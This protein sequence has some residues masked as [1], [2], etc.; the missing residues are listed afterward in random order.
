MR[1][2][3]SNFDPEISDSAINK[4]WESLQTKLSVKDASILKSS[5]VSLKTIAIG[6]VILSG[7]VLSAYFFAKS[8]NNSTNITAQKTSVSNENKNRLKLKTYTINNTN[9]DEPDLIK[10]ETPIEEL[11]TQ[12]EK[13]EA[14]TLSLNSKSGIAST[15]AEKGVTQKTGKEEV[16]KETTTTF[17]KIDKIAPTTPATSITKKNESG[18]EKVNET[19]S[20]E[21]AKKVLPVESK[22]STYE[23]SLTNNNGAL[24][25]NKSTTNIVNTV[26][27]VDSNLTESILPNIA[28]NASSTSS[29]EVLNS[30]VTKNDKENT[31]ENSNTGTTNPTRYA[32]DTIT[33]TEADVN[34]TNANQKPLDAIVYPGKLF[35]ELFGGY[36]LNQNKIDSDLI[37]TKSNTSGY[38]F[39]VAIAYRII[40]RIAI[41]GVFVFSKNKLEVENNKTENITTNIIQSIGDSLIQVDSLSVIKRSTL[42]SKFA[43]SNLFNYRTTFLN[44]Y[45]YG[46]GL[47]YSLLETNK[48][49]VDVSLSYN[50]K[51]TKWGLEKT[52]RYSE[53]ISSFEQSIVQNTL[54]FTPATYNPLPG[55]QIVTIDGPAPTSNKIET[56]KNLTSYS[57][58]IAPSVTFGYNLT[59][60]ISLILKPTYF[61]SVSKNK[62]NLDDS[63]TNLSQ[64]SLF[65]NFGVRLKF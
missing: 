36:N 24:K 31:V 46:I 19:K 20:V 17:E 8:Y 55:Q 44:S 3:F 37:T 49:L 10:K 45:S 25:T 43:N 4:N 12:K 22:E 6:V 35:F 52:S 16:K 29:N 54:S 18:V 9:A 56:T 50:L 14:F 38:T 21:E 39:G 60:S 23:K 59:N 41:Q 33:K 34:A 28:Q 27:Q 13:S 51:V 58:V 2:R 1:D 30:A 47:S 48:F 61:I 15:T 64:S 7:V 57:S 11:V 62:I 32:S 26:A 40:S 65:V 53:S 5:S 63:P 42:F